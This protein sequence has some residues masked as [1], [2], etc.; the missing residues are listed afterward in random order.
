MKQYSFLS[1]KQVSS[2]F[3]NEVSGELHRYLYVSVV[4][5]LYRGTFVTSVEIIMWWKQDG[6]PAHNVNSNAF[7]LMSKRGDWPSQTIDTNISIKKIPSTPTIINC[8]KKSTKGSLA[9]Q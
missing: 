1:N 7:G 2:L 5:T 6:A 8:F 9:Y 4:A 3:K